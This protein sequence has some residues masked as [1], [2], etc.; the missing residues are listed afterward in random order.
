MDY[1]KQDPTCISVKMITGVKVFD[2]AEWN[3]IGDKQVSHLTGFAAYDIITLPHR[4]L[5]H[6]YRQGRVLPV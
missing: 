2:A 3:T 1:Q 5:G 6:G 4:N